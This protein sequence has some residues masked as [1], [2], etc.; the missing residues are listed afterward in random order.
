[1]CVAELDVAHK[2]T[3]LYDYNGFL[4]LCGAFPLQ[5][6]KDLCIIKDSIS[7]ATYQTQSGLGNKGETLNSGTYNLGNLQM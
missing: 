7:N 2:A 1:M 4:H 5:R 6:S 3:L